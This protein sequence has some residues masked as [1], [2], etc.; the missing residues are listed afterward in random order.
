MYNLHTHT[1]TLLRIPRNI[2]RAGEKSRNYNSYN[3]LLSADV[4]PLRYQPTDRQANKNFALLSR[5]RCKLV[6]EQSWSVWEH[7]VLCTA[8]MKFTEK[9]KH[10]EA[11]NELWTCFVN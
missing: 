11:S 3:L 9:R 6:V 5:L 1:N 10:S 7:W 4:E 2:N 8:N